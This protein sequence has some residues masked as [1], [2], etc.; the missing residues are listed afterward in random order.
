MN[1]VITGSLG[2]ISKPLATDLMAK[3]HSV[4]IISS[5]AEKQADIAALGATP[6]IG[7]IQDIEFLRNTFNGADAV[8][9][10]EP[11]VNYFEQNPD[12]NSSWL[13][14]ANRYVQAVK[15]SGVKNLIHLSSIG[16]HTTEGVG[17][18]STHHKVE[19]ILKELPETVS[20]KFMR[21]VG[22][23]YNMYAFLP[24]IKSQ[25]VI[26]QN[27]GGDVK[28]PWVSP[29]DI[30]AAIAEEFEKPFSGR[31]VRYI[32]SD[33]VS[34]NEVAEV[35]GEAVGKPD[36]KWISIPSDQFLEGLLSAGLNPNTAKGLVEMNTGRM[37]NLYDDYNSNRPVLGSVKMKDFA[38]E[39][40]LVYHQQ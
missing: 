13:Y 34:P 16:A 15:N 5:K 30:A 32:A 35:L 25:G 31:T 28:E 37:Q 39:F 9:L 21:P 10:M 33:E 27:Y 17:M 6:A 8:Y 40:A 14:I 12:P 22:F 3:G 11:P 26:V 38:K 29:I 4:T 2:H 36:L 19:N 20:I 7:A 18:L 23:Y 24:S 1:I